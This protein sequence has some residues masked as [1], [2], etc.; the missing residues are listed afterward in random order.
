MT[1]GFR[2]IGFNQAGTR[3]AFDADYETIAMTV[4]R[5]DR[6]D[7]AIAALAADSEFTPT[8]RRLGCLRGISTLTALGLAVEVGD[9]HRFTGSSIGAYLGLVPSEYSSGESRRQGGIGSPRPAI[10]MPV[11]C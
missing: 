3:A 7:A 1:R 10:P 2:S 4:A 6:L 5:R 11:G 8:V 9:W